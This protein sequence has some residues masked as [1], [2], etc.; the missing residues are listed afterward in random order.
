VEKFREIL[1]DE[2]IALGLKAC[3]FQV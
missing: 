2:K 3:E 1:F